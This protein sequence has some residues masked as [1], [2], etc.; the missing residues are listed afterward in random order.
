MFVFVVSPLF[1]VAAFFFPIWKNLDF[2]VL[3][4]PPWPPSDWS[5]TNAETNSRKRT[6]RNLFAATGKWEE[7]PLFIDL[8]LLETGL[9]DAPKFS[10]L[11]SSWSPFFVRQ[12]FFNTP[13]VVILCICYFLRKEI[14]FCFF[15]TFGEH[16]SGWDGN[17]RRQVISSLAVF[18]STEPANIWITCVCNSNVVLIQSWRTVFALFLFLIRNSVDAEW[19]FRW[20]PAVL[21]N[22]T[23]EMSPVGFI[24]S[25]APKD[26]HICFAIEEHTLLNEFQVTYLV[27]AGCY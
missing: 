22:S 6:W 4:L 11:P 16:L 7:I 25:S 20:H 1:A 23:D 24:F 13:K 27:G 26:M 19:S 21:R 2:Q 17:W 15:R 5:D 12:F 8:R 18:G 14:C 9:R 10:E 3:F